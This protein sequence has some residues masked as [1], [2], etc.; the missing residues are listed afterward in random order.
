MV[1]LVTL[2]IGFM[3]YFAT[4]LLLQ[5]YRTVL[6]DITCRNHSSSSSRS[7]CAS[8]VFAKGNISAL[9][10]QGS[11]YESSHSV[12]Q[13]DSRCE[14]DIRIAASVR[15]I[16]KSIPNPGSKDALVGSC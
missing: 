2:Q 14:A 4:I 11:I 12:M 15:N 10:N 16:R 6:A 5:L 9:R 7:R 3:S 1:V 13:C 8:V